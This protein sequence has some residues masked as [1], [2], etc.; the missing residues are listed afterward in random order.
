MVVVL[1]GPGLMPEHDNLSCFS[2]HT[3]SIRATRRRT[4]RDAG[5]KAFYGT[6]LLT[7]FGTEQAISSSRYHVPAGRGPRLAIAL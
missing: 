3:T 2:F 1:I 7:T 5:K 4:A 6:H